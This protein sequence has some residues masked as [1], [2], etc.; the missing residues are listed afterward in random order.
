MIIAR[1]HNPALLGDRLSTPVEAAEPTLSAG[2]DAS[3]EARARRLLSLALCAVRLWHPRRP[4]S[5]RAIQSGSFGGALG[6]IHSRPLA[7]S[8]R[9][10]VKGRS[11]EAAGQPALDAPEH[12]GTARGRE[13]AHQARRGHRPVQ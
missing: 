4:A 7:G 5:V 6:L 3:V 10:R 13:Q 11:R 1:R 2:S 12:G 8:T 9:G